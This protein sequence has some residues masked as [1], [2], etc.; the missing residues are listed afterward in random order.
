MKT[1]TVILIKPIFIYLGT[2]EVLKV[3][4]GVGVYRLPDSLLMLCRRRQRIVVEDHSV[5]PV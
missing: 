1:V 2:V 3:T 5:T 4:I